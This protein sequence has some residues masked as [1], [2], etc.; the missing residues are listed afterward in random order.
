MSIP[1]FIYIVLLKP[2]PLRAVANAILRAL[3]PARKR[4]GDA[5]WVPNPNDPVVS[6]AASLGLY[7][8]PETAFFQSVCRPGMTFLDVGANTGYYSAWAIALMKGKGRIIAFE[9]DPECRS[10][11]EKTRDANDCRFMDVMP[12]AASDAE[13]EVKLFRNPDNR[14]DNRL[15]AND[16]CTEEIVI[17]SRPVD[18]VLSELGIETVDLIKI[19][20]QGFE[21]HVLPGMKATLARSPRVVL[22]M[23]FWP[24][25][26]AKAGSD[27]MALVQL[28]EDLGFTLF[29][30]MKGGLLQPLTDPAAL[31]AR[32]EGRI[33]TN[34]VGFRRVTS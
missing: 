21:G 13:G 19:D 22:L 10:F 2:R 18:V 15:Y 23:E 31:I 29:E 14:G 26:L 8:G 30:L 3:C 9:P 5:W 11:L 16:L 4:L 20:V 27:A 34:L 24:W 6:G 17:R 1:E 12:F 7:E 28:L 33:Y 25:G 32:L